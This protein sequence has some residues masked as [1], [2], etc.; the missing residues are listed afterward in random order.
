MNPLE[1]LAQYLDRL[2]RR[3]RLFTW[4]RGAAAIIGGAPDAKHERRHRETK[5]RSRSR[6]HRTYWKRSI[7]W[8]AGST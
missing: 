4:S 1:G 2:E 5:R 8:H 6:S 3:L 7:R